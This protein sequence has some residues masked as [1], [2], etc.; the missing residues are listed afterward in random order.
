[1]C[2]PSVSVCFFS[3]NIEWNAGYLLYKYAFTGSVHPCAGK[4]DSSTIICASHTAN[5]TQGRCTTLPEC[6]FS[7]LQ[8]KFPAGLP[9]SP[10]PKYIQQ[11]L[12]LTTGVEK[13]KEKPAEM[14]TLNDCTP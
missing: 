1:M 2:S 7:F 10:L 3:S 6:F 4:V 14:N 13:R 8:S 12:H 5:D 9:Y 11:F